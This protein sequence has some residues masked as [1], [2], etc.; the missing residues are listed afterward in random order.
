MSKLAAERGTSKARRL[1]ARILISLGMVA[2]GLVTFPAAAQADVGECYGNDPYNFYQRESWTDSAGKNK[3]IYIYCHTGPGYGQLLVGSAILSVKWNGRTHV[4]VC[5]MAPDGVPMHIK[6][7][8]YSGPVYTYSDLGGYG[9]GCNTHRVGVND[10]PSAWKVVG[11]DRYL[12]RWWCSW[13]GYYNT[14]YFEW[15]LHAV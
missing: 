13:G 8:W 7:E 5:D 14:P 12:R 15:P 9:G 10:D 6:V 11:Y 2:A 3:R 4:Q 1:L